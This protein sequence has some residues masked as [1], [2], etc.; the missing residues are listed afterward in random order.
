MEYVVS[1]N[2]SQV[3]VTYRIE[4]QNSINTQ[5]KKTKKLTILYY[6]LSSHFQM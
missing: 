2:N 5:K 3:S 4:S 6:T 1:N